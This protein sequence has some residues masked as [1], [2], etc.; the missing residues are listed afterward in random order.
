MIQFP[1]KG[2]NIMQIKKIL[3]TILSKIYLTEK[4]GEAN[5]DAS[6]FPFNPNNK[7]ENTTLILFVNNK[8]I[9]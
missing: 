6:K 4:I 2:G 3:T 1:Y 7:Q 9:K 8:N 5:R